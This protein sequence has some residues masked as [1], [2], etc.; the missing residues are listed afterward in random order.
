[1]KI[2]WSY[3]DSNFILKLQG[4]NSYINSLETDAEKPTALEGVYRIDGG[5][6]AF[7]GTGIDA[8]YT[9]SF[10]LT[11]T[12]GGIDFQFKLADGTAADAS[13]AQP[14]SSL[15]NIQFQ[16]AQASV[17]PV[18]VNILRKT[19]EMGEPSA[20]ASVSFSYPD[21]E[22]LL[23]EKFSIDPADGLSEYD[24]ANA[25]WNGTV[26]A[27]S[28]I[29]IPQETPYAVP[30]EFSLSLGN[31]VECSVSEAKILV[32]NLAGNAVKLL[33]VNWGG[34]S[35][36]GEKI[37]VKGEREFPE[38]IWLK[39]SP[40]TNETGY[41]ETEQAGYTKY[42][43]KWGDDFNYPFNGLNYKD[44]NAYLK[45]RQT[46]GDPASDFARLWGCENLEKGSHGRK[47]GTWDFRTI[48]AKNGMLMSKHMAA[49]ADKHIFYLGLNQTKALGGFTDINTTVQSGQREQDFIKNFISGAAVTNDLYGKGYYVA[50]LR[51]RYKGYSE[52]KNVGDGAWFAFWMHGPVH[53]FDLMEQTAGQ[54]TIINYVNQYHNGWGAP[55][56]GYGD[57]H[58]G[59]FYMKLTVGGRDSSPETI[60]QDNWWKLGLRWTDN[61][62]T[63]YYGDNKGYAWVHYYTAA[64]GN[65]Q[66]TL[67]TNTIKTYVNATQASQGST[68]VDTSNWTTTYSAHGYVDTLTAVPMA[69]MNVFLSTEI[70]NGWNG[71][72]TEDEIRH[73]PIWV[74]A[75]YIAY[76]VPA[77]EGQ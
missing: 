75:D 68:T 2:S 7:G 70:G 53:E 55:P 24:F 23:N 21:M 39:D 27:G 15:K 1:M 54:P 37:T 77:E 56:S 8:E 59:N 63:Y 10:P 42:V 64:E 5:E 17:S 18:H 11:T 13:F 76:Y 66:A 26:V 74:E 22:V 71:T 72:P 46:S 34:D 65:K 38:F 30:Y 69:P 41:S 40:G 73:L 61:Q 29:N 57:V 25:L 28:N 20:Q 6:K 19:D 14:F 62:V 16:T 3:D 43:L 48:E 45:A 58:M 33:T 50:K 31:D 36:F 12:S 51:T 4:I 35:L 9:F 67:T 60:V 47:F 44:N 49:D 52:S 32:P